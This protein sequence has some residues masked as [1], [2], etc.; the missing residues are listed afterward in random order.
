MAGFI[1]YR[2][3]VDQHLQMLRK[4]YSRVSRRAGV[5]QSLALSVTLPQ[6]IAMIVFQVVHI[7]IS[8]L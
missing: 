2:F 4:L 1:I 6:A 5:E 3:S 7:M 8:V